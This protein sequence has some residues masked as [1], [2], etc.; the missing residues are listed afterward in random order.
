MNSIER[1]FS[2][3]RDSQGFRLF[4]FLVLFFLVAAIVAWLA[5]SPVNEQFATIWDSIW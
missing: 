4:M 3:V 2:T 1:V 5:E